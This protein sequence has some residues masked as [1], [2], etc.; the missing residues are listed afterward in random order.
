MGVGTGPGPMRDPPGMSS[1]YQGLPLFQPARP[2]S[3]DP[4]PR[5]RVAYS[6]PENTK[7]SS[8]RALR[9]MGRPGL[10]PGTPRFSVVRVGWPEGRESLVAT[11]FPPGCGDRRMFAVRGRLSPFVGMAGASGPNLNSRLS[12]LRGGPQLAADPRTGAL[13]RVG[14]G[15]RSSRPSGAT[16]GMSKPRL[17]ETRRGSQPCGRRYE[18]FGGRQLESRPLILL[19]RVDRPHELEQPRE[20]ACGQRRKRPCGGCWDGGFAA[21]G[22][23]L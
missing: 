20:P 17:A 3:G 11:W 22:L 6:T 2:R 9:A 15:S 10:E 7:S 18:R 1:D 12:R 14:R 13:G 23:G 16:D 4:R 8:H 21:A 5:S 19:R